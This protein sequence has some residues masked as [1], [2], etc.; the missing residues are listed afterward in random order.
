[1]STHFFIPTEANVSVVI[2]VTGIPFGN[3]LFEKFP[4]LNSL[5][6]QSLFRILLL[7][8]PFDTPSRVGPSLTLRVLLLS[9]P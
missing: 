2:E 3:L 6:I 1:M 9:L 5:R 4:K 7:L 8:F